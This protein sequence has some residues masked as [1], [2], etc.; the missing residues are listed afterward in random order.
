MI[1]CG[2][3]PR[4]SSAAPPLNWRITAAHFLRA[5]KSEFNI[6]H[7]IISLLQLR[8]GYLFSPSGDHEGGFR[9]PELEPPVPTDGCMNTTTSNTK[10]PRGIRAPLLLKCEERLFHVD[11]ELVEVVSISVRNWASSAAKS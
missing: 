5:S 9:I 11:I 6:D 1:A 2:G 8:K 3:R 10:V 7:I 4:T